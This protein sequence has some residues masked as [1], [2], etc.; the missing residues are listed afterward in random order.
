MKAIEADFLEP[1]GDRR[2][3]IVFIGERI[4]ETEVTRCFDACLLTAP[5]MRRW[6]R[7]MRNENL[8]DDE[9]EDKLAQY[10]EGVYIWSKM[11]NG[12]YTD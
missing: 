8:S 10:F 7:I 5:E 9:R 12:K 6:E 2:Q 1:W 11:L 4:N 3:E